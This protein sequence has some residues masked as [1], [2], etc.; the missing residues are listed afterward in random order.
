M[1]A[2]LQIQST[3]DLAAEY[4]QHGWWLVGF[5]SGK[6]CPAGLGAV[7]WNRREN[8]IN[9]VER[10]ANLR[11]N[12][13]LLH[14]YSGTCSV[15]LD[16]L[17]RARVWLKERNI[18]ADAFLR[19]QGAVK[20][21]SG[22]PNRAKLLYKLSTPLPTLQLVPY[23]NDKGV[24]K[25]ALEFRCAAKSGTSMQCVLPPSIHPDTKQRYT[26]QYGQPAGHWSKLHELPS[27]LRELWEQ[28]LKT[29]AHVH[30]DRPAP[31]HDIE[32]IRELLFQHDPSCSEGEWYKRLMAV[33]YE[34]Q[35]SEEGLDLADEWSCN[36]SNYTGRESI[37]TRWRS[38]RPDH[39]NPITRASLHVRHETEVN[40]E[41]FDIVTE[42][43]GEIPKAHHLCTDQANAQRI[44][45]EF[46]HR[47]M[48]CDGRFFYWTGQYWAQDEGE[49]ARLAAKLSAL[50]GEE[51]KEARE[52]ADAALSAINPAL[53]AAATATPVKHALAKSKEGA[54][55]AA[56]ASKAD[57]LET[58]AIR[59]EMKAV[60]D[61]ALGLLRR[62][63]TVQTSALDRD[64]WALNCRN[65][66]VDL[67]TGELRPHN[68]QEYITRIVNVTY[69]PDARAPR[70]ESFVMEI[71]GGE[72]DRAQFLQRWFG[73]A[74]TGSVQ[75]QKF[76]V[77]V[78]P[79]GN[80]KSTLLDLV[81]GIL[82]EYA[83][84]AAP[85]LLAS[86]GNGA[87]RHP[88]EMADLFGRRLVT[89]HEPDQ[90]A[91]LREGFVKQA[92]GG[93]RIKARFMHKD[94][95]EFAPTHKLQLLTNHEPQIRGTDF[96]IWRRVLLLR[97]N[98]KFGYADAVADGNADRERDD[99][100]PEALASERVG[101]LTWI[102]RGAVE[103]H[104]AGLN[105]PKS[106]LA[107]GKIYQSEQDRV[108]QWIDEACELGV[109]HWAPFGGYFGLY[110]SYQTWCK[111][112]GYAPTGRGRFV[113]ELERLVPG[114]RREE[115]K[116]DVDG[117]RKGARGCF[118]VR[119]DASDPLPA[120]LDAL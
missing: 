86:S 62:L 39:P 6:K 83:G 47:L 31:S 90:G 99:R 2:Q 37:A 78:G 104:R 57:A 103:W 5:D 119:L 110:A 8:A 61:A 17:A 43:V 11:G 108:A 44:R 24:A 16:D 106:V 116:V 54:A 102:V 85:G 89:A 38:W 21:I 50:V 64:L 51:I 32:R 23:T 92:T 12:V 7:G 30:S 72:S 13:G 63:I 74:A 22:R 10:A 33:H 20:I 49:A 96:G 76:V 87:E 117:G 94:F 81:S 59:C 65:G 97:Y 82:G 120:G 56:L 1:N 77:H 18:D 101:V 73:Y 35:G 55:A 19:H 68:S 105:P 100:L 88:T 79:G 42:V 80:G 107:A 29:P 14:S 41:D 15:D 27:A 114:F 4:V 84:T 36:G 9:T 95:F 91:V 109:E 52:V 45:N 93:D 98:V 111:E 69:D 112:A 46:G 70:F 25:K 60:Q 75:E 28:E 71:M 67:R 34:T 115:R 113:N 118:G 26:W 53:L 58:W 66:V 3:G 48:V 40:A